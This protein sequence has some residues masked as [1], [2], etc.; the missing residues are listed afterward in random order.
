MS[1]TKA[2][3][4]YEYNLAA[5][6]KPTEAARDART[7]FIILQVLWLKLSMMLVVMGSFAFV[8]A[9]PMYEHASGFERIKVVAWATLVGMI[10]ATYF[11]IKARS[12]VFWAVYAII[13]SLVTLL[14]VVSS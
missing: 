7:K 10:L 3:P 8:I 13:L 9:N 4:L 6:M 12:I 14:I 11:P 2:M 5:G 1:A